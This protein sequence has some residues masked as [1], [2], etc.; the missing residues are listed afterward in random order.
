MITNNMICGYAFDNTNQTRN[1]DDK[2]RIIIN[3]T[4]TNLVLF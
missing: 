3:K 4:K 2:I 1:D